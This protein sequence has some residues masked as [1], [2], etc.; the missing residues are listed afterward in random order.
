MVIC[1]K[2]IFQFGFWEW[3]TA[4]SSVSDNIHVYKPQYVFGVQRVPYFA[5]A[6]VALLMALFFHRYMLRRLGLWKDA[7]N[8][9]KGLLAF[10]KNFVDQLLQP[11]FRYIRDLY[12]NMLFLDVF[13]F[14]MV[15]FNYTAFAAS[16]GGDVISYIKVQITT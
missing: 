13:C 7:N 3:N 4:T 9:K 1:V 2:F 6:D 10:M 5:V 8:Q 12:P 16:S 14:L 11:N 15:A